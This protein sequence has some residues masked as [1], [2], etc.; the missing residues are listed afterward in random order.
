MT[1]HAEEPRE[2]DEFL[3]SDRAMAHAAVV[4]HRVIR[5]A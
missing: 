5:T 4:G 1:G 3:G 2:P